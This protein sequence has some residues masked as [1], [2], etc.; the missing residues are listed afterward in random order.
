MTAVHRLDRPDDV[1][2]AYRNQGS[3]T[4][5]LLLHATLSTGAQLRPLARA[6]V[7]GG[8]LEVIAVDRR[9][10]GESRLDLARPLDVATHV[11]DLA[12]ILDAGGHPAAILVGHSFGGV[13]A[14]EF[15][16]RLPAR[17]LAVVAYEPPYGAVADAA[18]KSVLAS[19][20]TATEEAGRRDGPA[21][22][23][24]TF[25]R[26]VAGDAAWEALPK[27]SRR[28]LAGEG[29]GA[30]ADVSLR[31]LDPDGLRSIVAPVTLITGDAS[32]PFYVPIADALAARIG[33]ARRVRLPGLRHPAPIMDP[34]P[35][36][37]AIRAAL[38]GAW[39][40]G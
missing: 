35:I 22:A 33:T 36:A 39:I 10:S 29:G 14:L 12:A 30:V 6:L 7:A 2:I 34:E 32:E 16:A 25:L 37:A 17:A 3:G 26:A 15:A 11:A 13:V 27:R 19:L 18:T 21:A 1:R 8:G 31:G 23:A 38:A 40:G 28:F 9:G 24:E 20:A 4:P 5:V